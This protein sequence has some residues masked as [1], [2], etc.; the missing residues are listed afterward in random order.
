MPDYCF[1]YE[2]ALGDKRWDFSRP[3]LCKISD[4]PKGRRAKKPGTGHSG[5]QSF[6]SC[7][8]GWISADLKGAVIIVLINCPKAIE[9]MI[10]ELQGFEFLTSE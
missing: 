4:L 6:A 5:H 7:C 10:D 1:N 9:V 8:A 2:T 3:D